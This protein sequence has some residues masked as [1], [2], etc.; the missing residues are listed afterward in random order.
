M[1]RQ[2]RIGH[3][4]QQILSVLFDYNDRYPG[5]WV[6]HYRLIDDLKM[7]ETTFSRA[8]EGLVEPRNDRNDFKSLVEMTHPSIA[9]REFQG[10]VIPLPDNATMG[11][12]LFAMKYA[13]EGNTARHN[14]YRITDLGV[15]QLIR[16][17][18]RTRPKKPAESTASP[19]PALQ[20][21]S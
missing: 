2:S 18:S 13:W 14:F 4:Q 7:A 11:D 3:N 21:I 12:A 6:P 1:G 16:I 9:Y 10:D 5:Q 8:L 17:T 15:E 19:S 20:K